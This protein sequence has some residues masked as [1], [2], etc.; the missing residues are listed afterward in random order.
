MSMSPSKEL[1]N[2]AS[3]YASEAIRFDSQGSRAMA[4]KNY[5]QA[6]SCI[7]K[8]TKIYP[9]GNMHKIYLDRA[10]QYKERIEALRKLQ[11]YSD[12]D[13]KIEDIDASDKPS[14]PNVVESLNASFKDLI[15]QEKPDVFW[16]EVVGLDDAKKALRESITFP[17]KRPDLFPLGWPR[18]IL[19]YGPPGC[20]KTLLA[21]ATAAEIEGQF[22]TIDAAAIMSKWLGE[23]EKNVSKLFQSARKILEQESSSVVI[24]IDEIDS[25]LGTRNQE[26]GGEI[27]VKNQFLKE[28]DGI[29]DKNNPTHLY[30]I[31]ATNKPWSLDNAFLRRFQKRVYVQLP[32]LESRIHMLKQ[33]TSSLK[34]HDNIKFLD[35]AKLLDGY[36]GSDIRDVCQGVQLRVV[37]ELF[38]NINDN[39]ITSS[40][41]NITMHDFKEI[42]KSRMPTVSTS[43]L[44]AY[45]KWTESYKAL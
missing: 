16:N 28:M 1:E 45:I 15:L 26:I 2:V 19:L 17:T 4:I 27:R 29:I 9:D 32:S 37:S 6:I 33:H 13:I 3:R 44:A 20:G 12:N 35:L 30:V 39:D 40:P 43:M 34:T 38:D 11:N 5:Q 25:L 42:L 21:A 36:S 22:I 41:R 18:G 10:R 31:G 24:F 8:L 23:A 7:L 14:G